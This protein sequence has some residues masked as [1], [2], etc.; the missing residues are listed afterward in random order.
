M[1]AASGVGMQL[2]ELKIHFL[3]GCMFY[4]GEGYNIVGGGTLLHHLDHYPC[5]EGFQKYNYWPNQLDLVP[6][7]PYQNNNINNCR[8]E[9][10]VRLVLIFDSNITS[11]SSTSIIIISC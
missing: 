1:Y 11:T 3:T 7:F 6:Y 2:W 4:I 5:S 10:Q 9:P 8:G